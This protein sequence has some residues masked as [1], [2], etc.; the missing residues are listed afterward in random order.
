M[1]LCQ[2]PQDRHT[3]Q[4][5]LVHV[6]CTSG[7]I[8]YSG[9]LIPMNALAPWANL[10]PL[11]LCFCSYSPGREGEAGAGTGLL[12]LR[13]TPYPNQRNSRNEWPPAT[14]IIEESGRQT[15]LQSLPC[16]HS[17][18]RASSSPRKSR[19]D[20]KLW[21]WPVVWARREK[22]RTGHVLHVAMSPRSVLRS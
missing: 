9:T 14:V 7:Y 13:D 20:P 18:R 2:E 11:W 10:A 6:P 4:E 19:G 22:C 15:C 8:T 5:R 17:T 1:L 21:G 12:P 3:D 16:W